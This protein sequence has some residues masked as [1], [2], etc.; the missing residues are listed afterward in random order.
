MV[1]VDELQ[2]FFFVERTV[3][4][5]VV[6]ENISAHARIR[7]RSHNGALQDNVGNGSNAPVVLL[8]RK[9]FLR[10]AAIVRAVDAFR[11]L[12]TLPVDGVIVIFITELAFRRP[13]FGMSVA[14]TV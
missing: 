4:V 2:A 1:M 3:A 14:R 10:G 8:D 5:A 11:A 13:S 9:V 6:G 12:F 7:H